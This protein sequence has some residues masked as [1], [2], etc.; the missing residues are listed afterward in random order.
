MKISLFKGT[1]EIVLNNFQSFLD[2]K[3]QSQITSH[4]F[5]QASE[6]TL[7]LRA[8]DYELGIQSKIEVN[9]LEEG[10]GTVNGKQFLD[11]VKQLKDNEEITLQTDENY[12]LHIKQKGT[13]YKLQMYNA[14]EFPKF[15]QYSQ[16]KKIDISAS[17]FIDSIK[18]ITPAVS[19]N[20]PKIELNGA[21]LDIK[22]YSINL[23]ATDTKRLALV[24]NETQSIHTLSI[25]IPKRALGE[26]TKLFSDHLEIFYNE[27][28]LIIQ[29]GNYT[30]FTKLTNGKFPDYER[31]I[32]NNFNF[33]F[34][35]NRA[36]VIDSLKAIYSISDKVK[37]VFN[38]GEI[39]FEGLEIEKGEAKTKI[40]A[41]IDPS[42]EVI[43]NFNARNLLDFLSQIQSQTFTLH[44]NDVKSAF[45]VK[46]ESFSTI[47]MPVVV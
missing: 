35:L 28:Q 18:K 15:P 40:N 8:T 42:E 3:D 10:I 14:E 19:T 37:S 20:N 23:V 26:I 11:I 39:L 9:I 43:L 34:E 12:C 17:Q 25:I 31:I 13:A 44:I 47:I 32:P 2:K 22:E 38:K 30:F 33:N 6:N 36:D 24:K 1:L 29:T 27:N 16:D 5:L 45:M 21:F 7:L 46:S 41:E 4:I